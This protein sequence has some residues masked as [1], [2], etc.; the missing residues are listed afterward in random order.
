MFWLSHNILTQPNEKWFFEFWFEP[1]LRAFLV[2]IM[3][4]KFLCSNPFSELPI[5]RTG[6]INVITLTF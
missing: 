4:D 3:G 5:L 1:K 2:N 6:L